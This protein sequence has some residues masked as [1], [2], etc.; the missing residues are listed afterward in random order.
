MQQTVAS[1]FMIDQAEEESS[2][3]LCKVCR[4]ALADSSMHWQTAACTWR[5]IIQNVIPI[6]NDNLVIGEV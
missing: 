5:F 2:R 6:S 3:L 4:C 1:F